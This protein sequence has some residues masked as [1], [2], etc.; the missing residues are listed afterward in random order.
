MKKIVLI[1]S[2]FLLH[3]VCSA[4]DIKYPIWQISKEFLEKSDAIILNSDIS[5]V[6]YSKE[7]S[8]YRVKEV[9][10]ILNKKAD[11]LAKIS[12]PY[13]NFSSITYIK[14]SVYDANGVL[15]KKLKKKEI[16]D[17]KW[18]DFSTLFDD[19]RFKY[20][21]VYYSSY[22]F[23]IEFE[24]EI[25]NK[26]FIG[27]PPFIPYNGYYIPVI[28]STYSINFPNDYTLRYKKINYPDTF[29]I[30]RNQSNTT[31]IFRVDSMKAIEEEPYCLPWF[32]QSPK[33]YFAPSEFYYDRTNGNVETWEKMG[34]WLHELAKGR[35]SLSPVT[36]EKVKE[37]IKGIDDKKEQVKKIFEYFQ[38]RTRYVSIQ[39]GIGGYQPIPAY[40]VDNVGYGD[41]KA[42]SNYM[43]ALLKAV[44]IKSYLTV[45]YLGK[46]KNFIPDF[47]SLSQANHMI[48]SVPFED[49][50]IWLECTSNTIPFGYIHNDISGRTA[51]MV[52][53]FGGKIVY[54][55][56]YSADEN[57]QKCKAVINIYGNGN[58]N[59]K[60]TTQYYNK[61]ID[62]IYDLLS[63][64][65]N[66][67][68]KWIYANVPIPVFSINTFNL[69]KDCHSKAHVIN[70]ELNINISAYGSK[71]G[72]RIII[73][74]NL[75]NK[76][77]ELP[78][79]VINRKSPFY[80]DYE[81]SDCDS[82]EYHIPE[83]FTVEKITPDFNV[84]TE[85]GEFDSKTIV[86]GN[87]ILYIRYFK[88]YKG[89]YEPEKYND[90]I[91]FV[92]TIVSHDN[93]KAVIVAKN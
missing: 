42:L 40:Q 23:T 85:F 20:F 49:D 14:A 75:M 30:V 32:D 46:K 19:N 2:L 43:K 60:I 84:K 91:A 57:L 11:D 68:K 51:L 88:L 24:Y 13:D 34:L 16:G 70:E 17:F 3:T 6:I 76:A 9:R 52:T 5:I 74:L 35:D 71:S 77:N 66:E 79:E 62:K 31:Y 72:K 59:A 39:L 58:A 73:P 50:T 67:Q 38:S 29:E 65:L 47:S 86:N 81:Y 15:I 45:I 21:S 36:V 26:G 8:I 7:K 64:N 28:R 83:D 41:C 87:T 53:E 90:F 92:K 55:P 18:I 44:G 56:D 12:I 27:I 93:P 78:K 61:R 10:T 63:L 89:L 33:V 69:S 80:L 48:L 25:V 37:L 4:K 1:A 22:P 82:L 54:I